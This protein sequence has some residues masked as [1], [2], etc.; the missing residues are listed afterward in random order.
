MTQIRVWSCEAAALRGSDGVFGTLDDALRVLC[1][2]ER[3]SA[4]RFRFEPH[5]L[6]F[7]AAHRLLRH[8]L[9]FAETSVPPER[10]RF[11][12]TAGRRPELAAPLRACGLRFS[13]SHGGGMA[14]VAVTRERDV[15]VDVEAGDATGNATTV[16]AHGLTPREHDEWSRLH[17]AVATRFALERWTLKEAYLKARGVGLALD[18]REIGFAFVHG[19]PVLAAPP[20]GDAAPQRWRF[21]VLAPGGAHVGALAVEA[22]PS[23]TLAYAV[24]APA[25]PEPHLLRAGTLPAHPSCDR[26]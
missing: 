20:H 26:V 9:S 11:V 12:A 16:V 15:G 14:L 6:Q 8:A 4:A 17:G 2:D 7:V 1:D 19:V 5:R 24:L 18:P 3:E 23:E 22:D 21:A 10:W 13:L 25:L